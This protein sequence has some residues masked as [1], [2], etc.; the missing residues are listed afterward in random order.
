MRAM[1]AEN[2]T[3]PLVKPDAEKDLDRIR[4]EIQQE[5]IPGGMTRLQQYEK[6]YQR[7]RQEWETTG[8]SKGLYVEY[9]GETSER[10]GRMSVFEWLKGTFLRGKLPTLTD[11]DW[12]TYSELL[13]LTP[14]HR[15]PGMIPFDMTKVREWLDVG[16]GVSF[17]AA[18]EAEKR[19]PNLKV[20]P[21]D[22]RLGLDE[23]AD[24]AG[25]ERQLRRS[26]KEGIDFG[27]IWRV[28]EVQDAGGQRSGKDNLRII[29]RQKASASRS[30][31]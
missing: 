16:S 11:R 27:Q 6:D 19:Y 12:N 30:P 5:T 31:L 28:L 20:T 4:Q 15:G 13:S 14:E 21:V 3:E 24:L 10:I 18:R 26:L 7:Y 23:A 29:G 8:N 9:S 22:P 1:K 17:L 2:P 25:F